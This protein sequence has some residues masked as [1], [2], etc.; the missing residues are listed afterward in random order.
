[1]AL[2]LDQNTLPAEGGTFVNFFGRSAPVSKAPAMLAQRTGAAILVT[3]CLPIPGGRYRLSVCPPYRAEGVSVESATQE[4]LL[5]LEALIR[6]H[7]GCWLWT[8]KRWKFVPPGAE[9][10]DYP[11]YAR[12][13]QTGG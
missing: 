5:R 9:R 7:P 3:A 6:E 8:Y 13:L 2:L 10:A 12:M 4:I 1:M 11:Y